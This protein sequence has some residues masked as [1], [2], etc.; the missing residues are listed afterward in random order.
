MEL[1][2]EKRVSGSKVI[3]L[4]RMPQHYIFS[5]CGHITCPVGENLAS[6]LRNNLVDKFAFLQKVTALSVAT[7]LDP[8][9][10]ELGFCNQGC[11]QMA[12]ERLTR[13]CAATIDLDVPG[14]A[15]PQTPAILIRNLVSQRMVVSG[16]CWTAMLVLNSR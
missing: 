6:N 14:L 8:R 9:F 12:V 15:Q 13:E 11:A 7:L 10:K 4:L 2:E 1:L 16:P 5:R 3:P